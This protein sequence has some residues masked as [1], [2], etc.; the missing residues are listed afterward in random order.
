MDPA[1]VAYYNSSRSE[2]TGYNPITAFQI[3]LQMVHRLMAFLIFCAVTFCAWSSRR[4]LGARHPLARLSLMWLG[5]IFL[6]VI[7]GAATIWSNKAADVATA[8]VVLGALS[9]TTGALL[10]IV[11]FRVLI[12]V[13]A[14]AR[15]MAD[16]PAEADFGSGK[17]AASS[18]K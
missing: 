11:S 13:R 2:V 18:A 6:Q 5:L 14:G 9:L 4:Y 7:L 12:P 10:T 16:E 8:H 15:A 1:S 3:G 17:P